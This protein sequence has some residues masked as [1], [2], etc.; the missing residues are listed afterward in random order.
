MEFFFLILINIVMGTIFY[1]ILRLRLEKHASDYREKRLKR[2]I[3]E[4]ISVFDETAERNITILENRIEYLKKLLEKAGTV[5]N[6]DL[7]IDDSKLSDIEIKNIGIKET[8]L[9]TTKQITRTAGEYF[10]NLPAKNDEEIPVSEN[11]NADNPER[12]NNSISR[13]YLQ[14]K[15]RLTVAYRSVL[16]Y[17][18]GTASLY[19]GNGRSVELN[20]NP[21]T[22]EIRFADL[23]SATSAAKTKEEKKEL[24]SADDPSD[25]LENGEAASGGYSELKQMFRNSEDKYS[26]ISELFNEGYSPEVICECSGIPI[27]EI[28]LV[29]DLSSRS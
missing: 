12:N 2:E 29:L 17:K 3:D 5:D 26:L 20:D 24:S 19:N 16:G 7:K 14:I 1:L 11:I 10:P 28:K 8:V 13:Y 9:K 22:E 25:E 27:G 4:I 23:L 15:E 18:S 21:E 6:I